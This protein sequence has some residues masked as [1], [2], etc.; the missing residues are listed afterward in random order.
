MN[1]FLIILVSAF[2]LVVAQVLVE[3]WIN[4]RYPAD[5]LAKSLMWISWFVIVVAAWWC[6]DTFIPRT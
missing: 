5:R 4:R 3:K 1:R 6:V 2:V